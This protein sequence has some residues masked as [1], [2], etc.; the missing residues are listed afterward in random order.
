MQAGRCLGAVTGGVMLDA[1]AR[2]MHVHDTLALDR[3]HETKGKMVT[4]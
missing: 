4:R 1:A 2:V 3:A